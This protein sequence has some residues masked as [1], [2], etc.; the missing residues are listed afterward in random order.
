MSMLIDGLPEGIPR[1]I[2]SSSNYKASKIFRI[3]ILIEFVNYHHTLVQ[4]LS[5]LV[6]SNIFRGNNACIFYK[7]ELIKHTLLP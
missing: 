7:K 3:Y 4:T 2:P 5:L 6:N 1:K